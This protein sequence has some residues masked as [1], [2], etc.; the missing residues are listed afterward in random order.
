MLYLQPFSGYSED[1]AKSLEWTGINCSPRWM[2][3]PLQLFYKTLTFWMCI[4]DYS[5]IVEYAHKRDNSNRIGLSRLAG[6]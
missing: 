5:D 2:I 1:S 4:D 3:K 6:V